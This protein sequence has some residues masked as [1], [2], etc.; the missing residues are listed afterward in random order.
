MQSQ[1]N[2]QQGTKSEEKAGESS[3]VKKPLSLIV[4][5]RMGGGT[6]V[7]T[8]LAFGSLEH[9]NGSTAVHLNETKTLPSYALVEIPEKYGVASC[10]IAMETAK[11][12]TKMSKID[13][14]AVILGTVGFGGGILEKLAGMARTVVVHKNETAITK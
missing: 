14:V 2:T 10:E 6:V 1:D 13:R 8:I 11:G 5:S 7:S 3:K 12:V 9:P 4:E